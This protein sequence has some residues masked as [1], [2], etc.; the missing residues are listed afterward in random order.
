MET[1]TEATTQ[2]TKD[3]WENF[4]VAV[5]SLGRFADQIERQL[6][7]TSKQQ[8][9]ET[10]GLAQV[11]TDLEANTAALHSAWSGKIAA[12]IQAQRAK[13]QMD[14]AKALVLVSGSIDGKNEREREAQLV[15]ALKEDPAHR[16]AK[17]A[18]DKASTDVQAVDAELE[19]LR[20]V[21][22]AL[23]IKARLLTAQLEYLAGER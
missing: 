16:L 5:M 4:H 18:F 11:L 21:Q 14:E 15:L 2:P 17:A 23:K 10:L 8:Y 22:T 1:E 13:E 12:G 6:A 9:V 7:P 19:H 20:A 3:A